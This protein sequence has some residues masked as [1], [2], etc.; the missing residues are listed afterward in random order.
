MA[1][2][3]IA[4]LLFKQMGTI[5]LAGKKAQFVSTPNLRRLNANIDKALKGDYKPT[6]KQDEFETIMKMIK[7]LQKDTKA[8]VNTA[9]HLSYL[10]AHGAM[11]V[12]DKTLNKPVLEIVEHDRN[13]ILT[14]LRNLIK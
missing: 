9:N 1:I 10:N 12:Y 6:L 7:P 2:G 8:A 11:Q 5:R 3:K 13:P 4:N 14:L